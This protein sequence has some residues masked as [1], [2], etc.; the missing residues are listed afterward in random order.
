MFGPSTLGH[1]QGGIQQW[2]TL[3]RAHQYPRCSYSALRLPPEGGAQQQR[4]P[5]VSGPSIAKGGKK[6]GGKSPKRP[7]PQPAPAHSIDEEGDLGNLRALIARVEALEKEQTLC[8]FRPRK[9]GWVGGGE[10]FGTLAIPDDPGPEV[11]GLLAL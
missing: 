7:A 2:N 4:R 1:C 11:G 5:L 10:S 3:P 8:D 6:H 9:A